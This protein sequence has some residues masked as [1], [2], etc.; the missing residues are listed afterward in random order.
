[1]GMNPLF[2]EKGGLMPV[3]GEIAQ[4][5]AQKGEQRDER[6][7][8]AGTPVHRRYGDPAAF[9]PRLSYRSAKFEGEVEEL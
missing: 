7:V 1:M 6:D 2:R 8:D 9:E 5:N 4:R 3:M